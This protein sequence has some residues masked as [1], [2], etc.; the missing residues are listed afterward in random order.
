MTSYA[1]RITVRSPQNRQNGLITCDT[2]RPHRKI[3]PARLHE[4]DASLEI[5]FEVRPPQLA[6]RLNH[7][8]SR[9]CSK[10]R[11]D[12]RCLPRAWA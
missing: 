4:S 9:E 12:L 7:V 6:H 1:K 2:G 5:A 8:L 10:F 11:Q 3:D